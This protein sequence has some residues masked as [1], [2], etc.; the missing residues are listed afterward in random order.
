MNVYTYC[1]H[2]PLYHKPR[3]SVKGKRGHN[4]GTINQVSAETMSK[5]SAILG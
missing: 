2:A 1:Q 3:P 5:T 4:G